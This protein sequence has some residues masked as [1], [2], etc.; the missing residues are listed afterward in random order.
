MS[1]CAGARYPARRL[2]DI[3][4]GG[5]VI[6][7]AKYWIARVVPRYTAGVVVPAGRWGASA[8]VREG[9]RRACRLTAPRV[10]WKLGG[11]KD[12]RHPR[13]HL[14]FSVRGGTQEVDPYGR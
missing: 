2:L 1:V 8:Q 4:V 10:N 13:R 5:R 9:R 12:D 11:R 7:Q 6:Q 3:V 14:L